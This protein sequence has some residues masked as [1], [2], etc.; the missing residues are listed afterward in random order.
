MFNYFSNILRDLEPEEA[1]V[2][3]LDDIKRI[4]SGPN[5]IHQ[6]TPAPV[7]AASSTSTEILLDNESLPN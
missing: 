4:Y 6:P 7:S 3:F 1:F 5:W 2:L